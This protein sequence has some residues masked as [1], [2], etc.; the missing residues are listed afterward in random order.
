MATKER[1]QG[2]ESE[3]KHKFFECQL[4]LPYSTTP[5][6]M[7]LRRWYSIGW[8][9]FKSLEEARGEGGKKEQEEKNYRKLAFFVF[10]DQLY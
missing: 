10:F 5:T 8:G 4:T 2:G 6:E 1:D 7:T 3:G 9:P